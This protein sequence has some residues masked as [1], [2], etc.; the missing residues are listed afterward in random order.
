MNNCTECHTPIGE[1]G[2]KEGRRLRLHLTT[3]LPLKEH[4]MQS[5]LTWEG[6]CFVRVETSL[7]FKKHTLW[8]LHDRNQE[9]LSCEIDGIYVDLR[10]RF[11]WRTEAR[12]RYT[13][14]RKLIMK[15]QLDK[16]L[17]RMVCAT[18]LPSL[19]NPLLQ[20]AIFFSPDLKKTIY[21]VL[22][23]IRWGKKVLG[24]IYATLYCHHEQQWGPV[25]YDSCVEYYGFEG[26]SELPP[27]DRPIPCKP[28][29]PQC[30]I[31]YAE[32]KELCAL[33]FEECRR[34]WTTVLAPPEG[35]DSSSSDPIPF[36][37]EEGDFV[38]PETSWEGY[39]YSGLDGCSYQFA[40]CMMAAY[41]RYVK[42][43]DC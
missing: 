40:A 1:L 33:K 16:Y 28:N 3:G 8:W 23:E 10:E 14:I 19:I 5:I 9:L 15:T 41:E 18:P 30:V 21:E 22:K 7:F 26:M 2:L 20:F 34:A 39:L 43:M 6:L 11:W 32:D 38:V 35:G 4:F 27:K 25:G 31:M 24:S 17:S 42:C 29:K 13:E 36:F 12:S 37:S